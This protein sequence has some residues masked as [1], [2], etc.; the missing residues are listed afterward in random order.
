METQLTKALNQSIKYF[1]T[2][3]DNENNEGDYDTNFDIGEEKEVVY[4]FTNKHNIELFSSVYNKSVQLRNFKN[5]PLLRKEQSLQEQIKAL[6]QEL[7]ETQEKIKQN[8]EEHNNTIDETYKHNKVEIVKEKKQGGNTHF[9]KE[10][11]YEEYFNEGEVF[12][13][14]LETNETHK[15]ENYGAIPLNHD[16][17]NETNIWKCKYTGNGNKLIGISKENKDEEYNSFKEFMTAHI[18]NYDHEVKKN[19]MNAWKGSIKIK[20]NSIKEARGKDKQ[21]TILKLSCLSKLEKLK[22]YAQPR[23]RINMT[24]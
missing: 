24:K 2:Q 20:R 21:I 15:G 6:E 17:T 23:P 5:K 4:N 14:R 9:N 16:L 13:H 18:E 1:I 19:T 12:Y 7:T 8:N 10:R 22:D 11:N 3:Y